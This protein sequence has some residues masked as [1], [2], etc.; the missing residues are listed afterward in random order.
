M[1]KAKID[2][3]LKSVWDDGCES[4]KQNWK[5]GRSKIDVKYSIKD[6]SKHWSKHSINQSKLEG[7][8]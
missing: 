3:G 6:F 1:R 8:E 7:S 2:V 4:G 5:P